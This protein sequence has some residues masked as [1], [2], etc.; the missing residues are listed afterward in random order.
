MRAWSIL[1][2]AAFAISACAKPPAP[3]LG[4]AGPSTACLLIA[5][6]AKQQYEIDETHTL[7][8]D[9]KAYVPRCDWEAMGLNVEMRDYDSL[10]PLA[11]IFSFQRPRRS[12]G[13]RIVRVT[14]YNGAHA[15]GRRCRLELKAGEWRLVEECPLTWS[16]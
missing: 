2:S 11:S 15:Y 10:G 14:H 5:A 9:R 1:L 3:A 16:F 7:P 12:G 13:Y 8:L 4:S 6:I